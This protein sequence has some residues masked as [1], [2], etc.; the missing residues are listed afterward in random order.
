MMRLVC[1]PVACVDATNSN[2]PTMLGCA[3]V[4]PGIESASV[5][6]VDAF[7]RL[8]STNTSEFAFDCDKD[9]S[10]IDVTHE[11]LGCRSCCMLSLSFILPPSVFQ[12]SAKLASHCES[13]AYVPGV[14]HA[15]ALGAFV[16]VV[17][18]RARCRRISIGET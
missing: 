5:C 3:P 17:A 16:C 1:L 18:R 14:L 7:S 10:M 13:F 11:L 8:S 2:D 9:F 15:G 4:S 12:R 6:D